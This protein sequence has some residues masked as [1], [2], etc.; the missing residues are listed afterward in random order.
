M[1]LSV[2]ISYVLHIKKHVRIFFQ[3]F[4]AWIIYVHGFNRSVI[5]MMNLF[6]SKERK[7]KVAF[8]QYL[9]QCCC[10]KLRST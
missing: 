10:N 7:Y 3:A 4:H 9:L 6:F 1:I 8:L 2:C 5:T